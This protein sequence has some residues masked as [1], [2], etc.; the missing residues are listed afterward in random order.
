MENPP[1]AQTHVWKQKKYLVL[2]NLFT[3]SNFYKSFSDGFLKSY[4][5]GYVKV[6]S[7]Q[8]I[9]TEQIHNRRD[10]HMEVVL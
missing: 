6:Y 9:H 2:Q 1:H 5:L 10:K 8:V 3:L 4:F 7:V